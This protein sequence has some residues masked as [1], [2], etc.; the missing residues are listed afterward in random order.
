MSDGSAGPFDSLKSLSR[1]RFTPF[2][3]LSFWPM[4]GDYNL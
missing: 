2:C 4:L 3:D 1:Y